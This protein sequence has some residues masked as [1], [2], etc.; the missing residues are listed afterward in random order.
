MAMLTNLLIH[1]LEYGILIPSML[2]ILVLVMPYRRFSSRKMYLL[3]GIGTVI[4]IF[5]CSVIDTFTDFDRSDYL[6]LMILFCLILA[7]VNL[8]LRKLLYLFTSVTTVLSFAIMVSELNPFNI[9]PEQALIPAL[10]RYLIIYVVAILFLG[11]II[12]IRSSVYNLINTAE[13]DHFWNTAWIIPCTITVLN[14]FMVPEN[15]QNLRVGRIY[16]G[17][18]LIEIGLLIIFLFSQHIMFSIAAEMKEKYLLQNEAESY[19]LMTDHQK[20]VQDYMTHFT[21]IRHDFKHVLTT[22]EELVNN[23]D[24]PEL[25]QYIAEYLQEDTMQHEPSLFCHN[26]VINAQLNY[27][28]GYCKTSHINYSF[29]VDFPETTCIPELDLSIILGNLLNN[30]TKGCMTVD[31]S[32]RY[33]YLRSDNNTVG[34]LYITLTN[35]FDGTIITKGSK[36]RS[37]W[38]GEGIGLSSIQSIAGKYNGFCQFEGRDREFHSNVMLEIPEATDGET[39]EPVSAADSPSTESSQT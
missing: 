9:I 21:R 8:P 22:I 3:Y 27:Y 12:R 18:I 17:M 10:F 14:I 19:K 25:K 39:K 5:I 23:E 32:Q 16:S 20:N 1:V 28:A 34:S 29:Q 11:L 15:H 36:I 7:T 6:L 13:A 2:I 4:V 33:I 31:E 37:R 30:A 24:Y 38:Q 35:S 26:L